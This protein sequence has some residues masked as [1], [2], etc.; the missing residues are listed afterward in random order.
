M[1]KKKT[2]Y[3]QMDFNGEVISKNYISLDTCVDCGNLIYDLHEG[4][5]QCKECVWLE[6]RNDEKT[7]STELQNIKK[8]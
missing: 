3:F 4:A 5:K 7:E 8:S 6:V 2:A 1:L